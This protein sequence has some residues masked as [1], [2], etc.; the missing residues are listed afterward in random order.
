MRSLHNEPCTLVQYDLLY[1]WHV[2]YAATISL[3]YDGSIQVIMCPFK[4]DMYS[5]HTL[6][7]SHQ[8]IESILWIKLKYIIDKVRCGRL[9]FIHSLY[10]QVFYSYW[11]IQILE[12]LLLSLCRESIESTSEV[13]LTLTSL[14]TCIKYSDKLIHPGSLPSIISHCHVNITSGQ[15]N[16]PFS[17]GDDR[18]L[19]R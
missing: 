15:W 10:I 13:Y 12:T 6:I 16:F 3:A 7:V 19:I 5:F 8:S 2:H 14:S 11:K 9:T 4:N 18:Q 17:Q 1:L